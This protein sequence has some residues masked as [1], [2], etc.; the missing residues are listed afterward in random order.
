M[1]SACLIDTNSGSMRGHA[2]LVSFSIDRLVAGLCD[3]C[4][5]RTFT[6]SIALI[7]VASLVELFFAFI[8]VSVFGMKTPFLRLDP[9]I[10]IAATQPGA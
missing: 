4:G 7:S 8:S 1:Y 10:T 2:S 3:R 6:G 5:V 9:G